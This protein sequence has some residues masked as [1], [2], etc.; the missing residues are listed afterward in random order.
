MVGHILV[1]FVILMFVNQIGDFINNLSLGVTPSANTT[2]FIKY[3][4]G[5]DSNVGPN[6]LTSL[7]IVNER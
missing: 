1:A 7:G 2:M 3:R 6:V 4:V 5:G